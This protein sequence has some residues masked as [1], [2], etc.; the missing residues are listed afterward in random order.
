[1]HPLKRQHEGVALRLIEIPQWNATNASKVF[2]FLSCK[3]GEQVEIGAGTG[4]TQPN[5]SHQRLHL[6]AQLWPPDLCRLQIIDGTPHLYRSGAA[7]IKLLSRE[8]EVEL[9]ESKPR[10]LTSGDFLVY[11][12]ARIRFFHYP[13][14]VLPNRE[15]KENEKERVKQHQKRS[16]ELQVRGGRQR[17]KSPERD[18]SE[19]VTHEVAFGQPLS[20]EAKVLV[21]GLIVLLLGVLLVLPEDPAV[22]AQR[23][24]AGV[25]LAKLG[26]AGE[27]PVVGRGVMIKIL[28]DVI[29]FGEARVEEV[30]LLDAEDSRWVDHVGLYD[31][32]EVQRMYNEL[33]F[34]RKSS[35]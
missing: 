19:E 10:K 18:G 3:N 13:V 11:G 21:V 24:N 28:Q 14:E 35:Q 5:T 17:S 1:M 22:V 8:T 6:A 33:I 34:K 23:R 4:A 7:E 15:E 12:N 32:D 25:V 31:E 26:A 30:V 20:T 29:S 27:D 2:H 9:L 16:Q